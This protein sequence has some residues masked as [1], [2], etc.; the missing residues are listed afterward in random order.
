MYYYTVI[1][2]PQI[3]AFEGKQFIDQIRKS[4]DFF[5]SDT[6]LGIVSYVQSVSVGWRIKQVLNPGRFGGVSVVDKMNIAL[7]F[8]KY[9]P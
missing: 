5:T 9:P 1:S 2:N 4:Q 6:S 8:R 3:V 7:T